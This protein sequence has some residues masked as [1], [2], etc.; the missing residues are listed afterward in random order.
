L[1]DV[2]YA[3]AAPPVAEAEWV[4]L[5]RSIAAGDPLA[6][7]C[8]YDRAHRLVFTFLVR[9]T[10][11]REVADELTLDVFHDVWRRAARYQPAGGGSVLAWI[12][13][14]ARS[15]A[16]D[17]Q[18]FARRQKRTGG[19]H[20]QALPQLAAA[21]AGDALVLQERRQRLHLALERLTAAEREAIETAFFA[22]L[23]HRQVAARLNQPLGTVKTRI[24][25]GLAKLR[26]A[27]GPEAHAR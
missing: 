25:S 15:R 24:R 14:Q 9:L 1:G 8:L 27:L 11:D 10:G 18:R 12:M 2:L 20:A 17:H 6:L 3:R 5:L 4:E 22:Q 16:I 23:T 13:N 19:Q 26:D 21:E 7:R